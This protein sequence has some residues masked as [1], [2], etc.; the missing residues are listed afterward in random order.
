MHRRQ[1][2]SQLAAGAAGTAALGGPARAQEGR[3][4]G[5]APSGRSGAVRAVD[6]GATGDGRSDDTRAIQAAIDHALTHRIPEVVLG[7]GRFVTTATLQLGYGE[8]FHTIV[9]RGSGEFAFR[10]VT[11]G[12]TILPAHTDRPA[13]NIQGGRGS[14]VRNLSIVGKNHDY[15]I[16]RTKDYP[17]CADPDPGN[18]LDP[19]LRHGLRRLAPYAG[20]TIDAYSGQPQPEDYGAAP[21]VPYLRTQPADGPRAFS[22]DVVIDRCGIAGFAVGVAV[23]PC[24][25]DGN[26]DFVRITN[27]QIETCVYGI[28]VGNSQ[29]RNVAVRDVVYG[30]LHTFITNRAF[31]RAIGTLGGVLDNVSGI[32]SYQFMDVHAARSTAVTVTSLYWEGQSRI[33]TWSNESA[34]NQTVLFQTCNF[35]LGEQITEQAVAAMLDCGSLGSVR[36][37]GCTFHRPSRMFHVVRGASSVVFDGCMFGLINDFEGKAFYRGTPQHIAKALNYTCGGVFRHADPL[38]LPSPYRG[39]NLGLA[40]S[41]EDGTAAMRSYS[42]TIVAIP[43]KREIAHHYARSF[44]ERHGTLWRIRQRRKP[45]AVRKMPGDGLLRGLERTGPDEIAITL[46]PRVQADWSTHTAPG[47]IVYD[48][49]HGALFVIATV[50]ADDRECRITATQ[51]TGFRRIGGRIVPD[52]PVTASNGYLWLYSANV[53]LGD[54]VFSGDFTAGSDVVRNVRSG[55]GTTQGLEHCLLPGDILHHGQPAGALAGGMGE[56]PYGPLTRVKHV[57]AR[58][59]EAVLDQPARQ[60]MRYLLS[61]IA[62]D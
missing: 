60:T 40:F 37:V 23:Q 22:S 25:C 59:G 41:L 27:C 3:P 1:F 7:P 47:D 62:L 30:R 39:G 43:G 24:D 16:E 5:A 56:L 8:A 9:L 46:E 21:A 45:F 51:M 55:D 14:A 57:S 32:R 20:I 36:F 58:S 4:S 28:A 11:A 33:G 31:G 49:E 34:L 10:G 13:I 54:A 42:D 48:A 17:N 44:Q 38:Q 61:T 50:E 35:F 26:G 52:H 53:M 6:F 29:S 2:M 15:L 18:W 19:S 12:T